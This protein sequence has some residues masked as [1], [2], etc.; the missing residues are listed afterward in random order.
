[1]LNTRNR[2]FTIIEVI[3]ALVI[4]S[5]AIL[6]IGI[7]AGQLSTSAANAELRALALASVE[8]RLTR[9]A[10]DPRYGALDTLYGGTEEDILGIEG[11]DRITTIKHVQ[12]TTP[13]LDYKWITV[14]VSGA[15][16]PE[17]VVRETIRTAS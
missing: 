4:L 12:Q 6:G 16:L 7:S 17:P 10:L 14:T 9:I 8:D 13:P 2:G 1:M 5:T 11:I 15:P 3:V